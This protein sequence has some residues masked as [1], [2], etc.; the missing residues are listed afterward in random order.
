[1]AR[2]Q[3]SGLVSD[4]SGSIGGTTYQ[5][6]RNGHIAKSKA[7][8]PKANTRFRNEFVMVSSTIAKA[9]QSLSSSQRNDWTSYAAFRNQIK[10][11][12]FPRLQTGFDLFRAINFWYFI[13]TDTI[14]TDPVFTLYDKTELSITTVE[15]NPNYQVN[16]N[17][18]LDA[19]SE[20]GIL[21]MTCAVRESTS[22]AGTHL[23]VV[24]IV[25]SNDMFFQ[26]EDGSINRFGRVPETGQK[27][28]A[29]VSCM[30]FATGFMYPFTTL[31][32]TIV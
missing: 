28:F 24:K 32:F 11:T 3:L 15:G 8:Q 5:K 7:V 2:I 19:S 14:F 29:S 1:M 10:G 20:F 30:S 27:V 4:I 16:L 9:W 18:P 13:G 25:T 6:F 22:N 21:K 26:F 12:R 17:R 31:P 23:K